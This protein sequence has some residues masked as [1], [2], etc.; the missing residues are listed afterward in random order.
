MPEASGC[1]AALQSVKCTPRFHSQGSQGTA[2]CVCIRKEGHAPAMAQ[3]LLKH[4]A[5]GSHSACRALYLPLLLRILCMPFKVNRPMNT[6]NTVKHASVHIW[7]RVAHVPA[8]R[9]QNNMQKNLAWAMNAGLVTPLNSNDL[10]CFWMHF[11]QLACVKN[12]QRWRIYNLSMQLVANHS[13]SCS[14]C[15]F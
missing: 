6:S 9:Q 15:L 8:T 14:R 4:K 13:N 2:A 1:Y 10:Y 11:P 5:Q 12:L 3:G 7:A